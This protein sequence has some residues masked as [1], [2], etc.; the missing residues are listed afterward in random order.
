[1]TIE[2]AVSGN[3]TAFKTVHLRLPHEMLGSGP[4][5]VEVFV[6]RALDGVRDVRVPLIA[7]SRR[8]GIDLPFGVEKFHR[9]LYCARGS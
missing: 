5:V 3:V 7:I 6:R 2:R 9:A 4:V 8:L 1:L